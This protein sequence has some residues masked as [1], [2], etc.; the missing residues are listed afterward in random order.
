MAD[1]VGALHLGGTCRGR[2]TGGPTVDGDQ[3]DIS[4]GACHVSL[5]TETYF[6]PPIFKNTGPLIS[7]ILNSPFFEMDRAV[8]LDGGLL[9]FD[10][11]VSLRVSL[12]VASMA[13]VVRH[14]VNKG[15]GEF[16]RAFAFLGNILS[17]HL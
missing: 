15:D 3:K 4:G 13:R 6:C 14:H 12:G 2:A 16:F 9:G 7:F 5:E 17:L 11:G 10:L 8:A 1:F